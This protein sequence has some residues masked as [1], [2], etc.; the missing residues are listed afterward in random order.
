MRLTFVDRVGSKIF[1]R[2]VS[3]YGLHERETVT[4]FPL[5]LYMPD[6]NGEGLSIYKEPLKKIEFRRIS[7]MRD[8]Q[9]KYKD[10]AG[11]SIYG[12]DDPVQQFIAFKYPNGINA[13]VTDHIIACFDIEVA[14]EFGF[15]EP[16]EATGEVWSISIK[17]FNGESICLGC[18]EDP[19]VE[20]LRY[21]KCKNEQDLLH[22]FC[23]ELKNI[24]PTILTGWNIGSF[25]IPYLVNRMEKVCGEN[26]SNELSIFSDKSN[27]CIQKTY[28][29]MTGED[30][31]KILGFTA[32]DYLDLYKK[33]NTD[34]QDS[35]RLDHIGDVEGVGRKVDFSMYGNLVGCYKEGWE[36]FVRYN[37]QDNRIVELL[38]NKKKFIKLAIAIQNIASC[39]LNDTIGTVKA[40]D[41]YIYHRARKKNLVI[42]P[43]KEHERVDNAG[44][45]V[46]DVVPGKYEWVTVFDATSLYPSIIRALNIS[47][48]TKRSTA[49]G[50][51]P[52]VDAVFEGKFKPEEFTNENTSCAINGCTYDISEEGLIPGAL[53]FLSDGRVKYKNEMKEWKRKLEG[54]IA[55][56]K[57][58]TEIHHF[59]EEVATAD[60]YQ[61]A[62]KIF[63]NAGYG[64]LTQPAFRYFDGDNSE[65]IT[66]TGQYII[67]NAEKEMNKFI[68]TKI[69]KEAEGVVFYGDTDSTAA[70]TAITINNDTFAIGEFFDMLT[71]EI[72]TGRDK[73]DLYRAT[74]NCTTKSF[75]GCN[76]VRKPIK[77]IMKHKVKKR[78]YRINVGGRSVEITSDHSIMIMRDGIL[79]STKVAELLPFDKL[80][81]DV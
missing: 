11:I 54:A 59:E 24:S 9:E 13:E 71:T 12:Q 35:Y 55:K 46:K 8:F 32:L 78:M 56:E 79:Q 73:N 64:A 51:L 22:K 58:E 40:W 19:N 45:Y 4:E 2:Y 31:Y 69:G 18:K 70:N 67:R 60:A 27:R 21:V 33:F 75:D 72:K 76:I 42:P 39:R 62:M 63:A 43:K 15:P 66:L 49:K 47:P 1:H 81:L 80:I 48:E 74:P 52:M 25:D 3:D 20:G 36:T 34:K 50:K 53:A 37:D 38:D 5:A 68:Q 26:S 16:S 6:K 77:W 28:N 10:V 17:V 57:P 41:D 7:E 29:R 30:G 14:H 23:I 65:A 44:G 61:L